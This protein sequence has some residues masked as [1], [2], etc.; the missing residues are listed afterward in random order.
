MKILLLTGKS[1]KT[2]SVMVS[3]WQVGLLAVVLMAGIGAGAGWLG[4]QTGAGEA[5]TA[6]NLK[7]RQGVSQEEGFAMLMDKQRREALEA[8]QQTRK[9]LDALALKLGEM[10][11]R[12]L[13]L[14]ALGERL[15][16]LGK[17]DPDEFDFSELPPRGGVDI[18]TSSI[19]SLS[20]EDVTREMEQIAR[21]IEDR[22]L[23][24]TVIEDLIMNR[25]LQKEIRPSGYPVRGGWISSRFGY[26]KHPFTGRRT[27]H[28]GVDI[29]AKRGTKIIAAASGIVSYSGKRAGYGY[30]VEIRHGNGYVTRYAHNQKNLVKVGDAVSKGQPIATVGSSGRSTGPHLHFEV[31]L[32][33]ATVNPEKYIR[34]VN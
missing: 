2:G 16:K 13:R 23:K 10:Q 3:L 15:T 21:T 17:L 1:H 20:P 33:G 22:E 11:S 28:R 24:L 18:T 26:R 25:E 31:V 4:Y 8:K 9:H 27:F 32:N 30:T 34:R 14:D 7:D 19:Q 29:P 5:Q 12:L 6:L